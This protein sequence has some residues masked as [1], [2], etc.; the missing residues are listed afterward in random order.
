MKSKTVVSTIMAVAMDRHS[1]AATHG[2][3][4]VVTMFWLQSLPASSCSSC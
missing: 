1:A 4:P 3:K 2:F